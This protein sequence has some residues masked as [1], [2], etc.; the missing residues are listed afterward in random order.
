MRIGIAMSGGVDSTAT[1]LTLQADHE[2]H[3]FF[4][5]LVQPDFDQQ[6]ARVE[7]IANKLSIDLQVIDLR[8]E[9]R[10]E[11]LDYF[12]NSYYQGETPN[13][14]VICN[15]EIKFGLFLDAVLAAGMEKMATGHYARLM[16]S[17]AGYRL[18]MGSDPHKD[19]T[20]FLSRLGQNQLAQVLFPLGTKHKEEIYSFV[21]SRGFHDFRGQ[22]SQDVCFLDNGGVGDFITTFSNKA[23]EPGPIQDVSGNVLG[24]HQGIFRYTIG[25]RK[26]L[27][28]SAETPLYVVRLDVPGNAVIVGKND[29]LFKAEVHLRDISWL[30]GNIPDL[31]KPYTIRIRY[32][33]R[34]ASGRI[35]LTDA[36]SGYI[37]FSAPQ[38]AITPGQF[39]V[40]Y[41][42]NELLGS[43]LIILPE[44]H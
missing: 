26:G 44:S 30:S 17:D 28:I 31:S 21:E 23:N 33:H 1:A 7:A 10:Q 15:R 3:G 4:M 39:A 43:G 24:T 25:Q 34:G 12:S 41:D 5:R 32:T 19:Q 27:G 20:Y 13:P 11:V 2:I 22:E 6:L 9:F 38:R 14:C 37:T 16:E 36:D 35:T 40:I 29:D 18:F 8:K 42:E